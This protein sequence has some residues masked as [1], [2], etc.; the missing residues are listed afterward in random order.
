M[1]E[2]PGYQSVHEGVAVAGSTAAARV[3][4]NGKR[5][6]PRILRARLEPGDLDRIAASRTEERQNEKEE[7]GVSATLRLGPCVTGPEVCH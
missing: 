5:A 4:P 2:Q 1:Q 7:S 6:W 3:Q